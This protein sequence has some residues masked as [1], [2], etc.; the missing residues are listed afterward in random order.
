MSD[1]PGSA[2]NQGAEGNV[3]GGG[4]QGVA[5]LLVPWFMGGGHGYPVL[6]GR[7]ENLAHGGLR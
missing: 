5:Q 4:S 1:P 6:V 2:A 7:R 3:A